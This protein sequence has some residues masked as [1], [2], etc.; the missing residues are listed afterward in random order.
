MTLLW[1]YYDVIVYEVISRRYGEQFT[2][3]EA[4]EFFNMMD[5]DGDG[6]SYFIKLLFN[7]ILCFLRKLFYK[8]TN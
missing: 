4:N 1:L 3:D 2:E 8:L 6:V 5:T 7:Y